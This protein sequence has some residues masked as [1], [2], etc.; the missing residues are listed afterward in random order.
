M[1]DSK[2]IEKR[3]SKILLKNKCIEFNF[4]TNFRLTSGKL[5]PVYCDCRK[6]ISFTSDRNTI[7]NFAVKKIKSYKFLD[8]TSVIAGGESAGI[9][10][11]SLIAQKIKIT[12]NLYKKRTKKVWEKI[13]N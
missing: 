7:M 4:K 9:P 10:Y 11:A 2:Y 3:V 6:L 5:S 12:I 13:S 8:S 1:I